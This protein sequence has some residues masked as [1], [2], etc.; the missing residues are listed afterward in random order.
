MDPL[1]IGIIGIVVLLIGLAA[2]IQIALLL[3]VVGLL[4]A[5]VLKGFDAAATLSTLIAFGQVATNEFLVIP[6]FIFMGVLA[7]AGGISRDIYN[8]IS[9]WVGRV[10]AAL[11]IATVGSVAAFGLVTGSSV[12]TCAVFSK[13][14][15]PEMRR[16]GMDKR[17]AYGLIASAGPI[18]VFIPPS[19]R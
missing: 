7:G 18:A 15:A 4:G 16:H 5:V 8:A 14:S 12:A 17:L 9:L 1:L 10:R 3:G 6:L 13:I 11:G 2:G 19:T